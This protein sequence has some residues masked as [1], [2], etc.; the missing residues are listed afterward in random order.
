M[1]R[2]K[3]CGL[4]GLLFL[5]QAGCVAAPSNTTTPGV[6]ASGSATQTG[7]LATRTQTFTAAIMPTGTYVPAD[8]NTPGPPPDLEVINATIKDTVF[9]LAEIRNNTDKPII[10]PGREAAFEFIFEKW[11]KASGKY[12]HYEY[13]PYEV[14]PG[15]DAIYKRTNCFLYPGEIGVIAFLFNPHR[16]SEEEASS[17]PYGPGYRLVSYQGHYR[18]MED[19]KKKSRFEDYPE[20]LYDGFHPPAENLAFSIQGS[21]IFLNFDVGIYV[22]DY[23][24]LA[25]TQIPSW[26]VLYDKQGGIINILLSDPDWCTGYM[27]FKENTYHLYGVGSDGW[28]QAWVTPGAMASYWEPMTHLTAEDLQRVDHI[29][30][31]TEIED[32]VLCLDPIL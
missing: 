22:P 24:A 13:K 9:F 1:G 26:V 16:K 17:M 28:S 3:K 19:L 6:T 21:E 12:Y 7:V 32:D 14:T 30:V 29:R 23:V 2:E 27:C 4:L 10:L 11:A 15:V 18:R 5:L 31:L 8:T 25:G 20:K